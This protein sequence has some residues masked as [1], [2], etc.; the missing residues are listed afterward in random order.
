MLEGRDGG[1]VRVE[2]LTYVHHGDPGVIGQLVSEARGVVRFGGEGSGLLEI[3][4]PSTDP[5]PTGG[6]AGI[7]IMAVKFSSLAQDVRDEIGEEN[8]PCILAHSGVTTHVLL[9]ARSLA[10]VTGGLSD[11]RGKIRFGLARIGWDL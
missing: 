7:R 4:R 2:R 5:Q 8:V 10:R 11:L 1:S 6:E 9:P 3:E